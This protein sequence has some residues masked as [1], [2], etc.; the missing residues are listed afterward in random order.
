MGSSDE[1][2]WCGQPMTVT[3][4]HPSGGVI[5]LP[6]TCSYW[7]DGQHCYVDLQTLEH[8]KRCACGKTVFKR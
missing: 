8:V 3:H 1:M 5:A 4:A 7:A 2:C 6:D